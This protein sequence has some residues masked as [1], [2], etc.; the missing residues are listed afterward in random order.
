M[1]TIAQPFFPITFTCTRGIRRSWTTEAAKTPIS[2]FVCSR[3]DY[4]NTVLAKLPA[5]TIDRLDD[6]VHAAAR[7]ISGCRKYDHITPVMCDELH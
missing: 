2:S 4:R 5:S 6:V 1:Q 3:I 7:L